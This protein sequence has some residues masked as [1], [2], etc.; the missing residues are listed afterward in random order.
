MST[1]EFTDEQNKIF[2]NLSLYSGLIGIVIILIGIIGIINFFTADRVV[3]F[4]FIQF[5]T[6]L[7]GITFFLPINNFRNITKT[8]GRDIEELIFGIKK[9]TSGWIIII[10]LLAIDRIYLFVQ[11]F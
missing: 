9:L 2:N 5:V 7:I 11:L 3:T 1:Y 4:L 10:I 6:I 8:K